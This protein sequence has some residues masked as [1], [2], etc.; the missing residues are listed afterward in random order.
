MIKPPSFKKDAVP[1]P[2]GWHDPRTFELLVAKK[3]KQ[4]DIDEY[5]G[6]GNLKSL[7]GDPAVLPLEKMSRD[8]LIK[9]ADEHGIDY[10]PRTRNATLISKLKEVM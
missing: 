1:S 4:E 2:R 5:N 7:V 3:L 9:L 6:V 8:E 10:L